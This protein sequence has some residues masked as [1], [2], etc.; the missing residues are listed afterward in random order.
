MTIGIAAGTQIR[1]FWVGYV[2]YSASIELPS[3]AVYFTLFIVWAGFS[4][5]WTQSV[6]ESIRQLMQYLFSLGIL[7][8]IW[9]V[10]DT[11][12][13]ITSSFTILIAGGWL[14]S[15]GVF[16]NAANNIIYHGIN[17]VR[18]GG[19]ELGAIRSAKAD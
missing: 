2:L 1:S 6:D 15:I 4:F 10:N 5:L 7:F 19:A 13:R 17:N 16:L 9:D 11:S 14:V 12:E 8:L 18:F 3:S